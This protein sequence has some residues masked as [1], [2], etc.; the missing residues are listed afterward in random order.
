MSGQDLSE[1]LQ[2]SSPEWLYVVT[3]NNVLKQLIVPFRVAVMSPVGHLTIGQVVYVEEVKI[4][5][6]LITVFIVEG[7][8]YYYHHFD[9][10]ID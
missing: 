10:L 5:L 8:A 3:W 6:N 9:I 2:Y 7:N 1:L 4:T